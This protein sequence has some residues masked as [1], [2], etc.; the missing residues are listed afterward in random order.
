MQIFKIQYDWYEGEH[1]ETL[2]TKDVEESEFKKDILE[3]AAFAESLKGTEI[4]DY[5]YLGFNSK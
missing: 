2:I 5:N 3:A 4:K 1:N